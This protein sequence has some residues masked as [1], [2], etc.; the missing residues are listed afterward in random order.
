MHRWLAGGDVTESIKAQ[1]ISPSR[2]MPA[3][4]DANMTHVIC[5]ECQ[6]EIQLEF[7]KTFEKLGW[8]ARLVRSAD[9]AQEM[10]RERAPDMI[11]F[12]CDGL[13][14]DSL[15]AFFELDRISSLGHTPPR[16]ILLL[17]PKQRKFMETLPESVRQRF[18]ILQKPLKMRAVKTSL[19]AC[20]IRN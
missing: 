1:P 5:V 14:P 7:R 6:E 10:A 19:L 13:G 9:S 17:G 20:A 12:D 18:E 3:A 15:E 11:V 2:E 4:P 16:G 8:R